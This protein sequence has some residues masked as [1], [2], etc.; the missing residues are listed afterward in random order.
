MPGFSSTPL[1]SV[2]TID[3]VPRREASTSPGTPSTESPR[4]SSGSQNMASVRRR[5]TSTGSSR[6][7]DRSH[8]LP[9]RTVRSAAST[10]A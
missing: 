6:P 5:I 8:T 1:P 10:S 4:S 9:S 2:L 3:T 7:R